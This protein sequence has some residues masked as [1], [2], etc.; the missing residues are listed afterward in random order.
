ML[1][2]TLFWNIIICLST[3]VEWLMLKFVL[4]KLGNKKTSD[5]MIRVSVILI[6][7][8]ISFLTI[9]NVNPNLKLFMGIIMGCLLYFL[10]YDTNKFKAIIVNLVYWMVL[11]GLDFISLNFILTINKTSNIN[12][13]LK[14]DMLR[15]ELIIISK[16]LLVSIIP[17]IKSLKINVIFKKKEIL[18]IITLILANILSIVVIFT[19]SL[20]FRNR[21]LTQELILLFMSIMLILSNISL[22][23]IIGR[24][25]KANNIELENKL[26]IEKIEMQYKYYS[27]MKESQLKVRKLY[28]DMNNHIA[29]IKKLYKNNGEVDAYIDGI[30]SELHSC[31]S[32][33][34]TGSMILDIIINDKKDICDKNDIDFEVD[35]N[36]SRCNFIDMIDICSIFS[37]LIDNAIEA[38]LKVDNRDRYIQLKGNIVNNFFVLKCENNKSNKVELNKGTIITDKKDNFVHGIGIKS[39]KGSIEKYNGEMSIDFTDDKFKVQVY[40]PLK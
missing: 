21:S 36:F 31:K 2:S 4:D 34:S 8:I 3:M 23:K 10:N 1:S 27:N 22:I 17:I 24:I 38:S 20:D 25:I 26:I 39:I 9:K 37:N 7:F 30:T 35:L 14:N 11:I 12:E 5:K 6:S 33:I 28:H 29:C 40:I 15:L 19:L 32:I 16:L 18:Y 13:L